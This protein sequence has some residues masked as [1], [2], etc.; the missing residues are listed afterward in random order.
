MGAD[1]YVKSF[2]FE[3]I[4]W[5]RIVHGN[6]FGYVRLSCQNDGPVLGRFWITDILSQK[7]PSWSGYSYGFN[8]P[9]RFVDPDGKA[10]QD[11]IIEIS[12]GNF[13]YIKDQYGTNLISTHFLNGDIAY[14]RMNHGTVLIKNGSSENKLSN[15]VNKIKERRENIKKLEILLITLEM[16]LLR[17][18]I[19]LPHLL[20]ERH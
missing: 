14:T 12:K 17:Q 19:L 10:P 4:Q 8:N 9:L 16:E 2:E 15:Y 18:V 13:K 3:A 5:K 6:E 7:M 11:K 1:R 20:K